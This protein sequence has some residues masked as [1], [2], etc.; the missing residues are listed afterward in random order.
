MTEDTKETVTINGGKYILEDMSAEQQY[1]VKQLK[2]LN[3][4]TSQ[5]Q[6]VLDQCQVAARGFTGALIASLKPAEETPIETPTETP[7]EALE[8][9]EAPLTGAAASAAFDAAKVN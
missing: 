5:T 6:M 8:S 4:K 2:D 1:M 9:I 7:T 3:N